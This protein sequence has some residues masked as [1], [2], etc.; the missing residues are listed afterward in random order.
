MIFERDSL[1]AVI[2]NIRTPQAGGKESTGTAVFIA[3]DKKPILLSAAHVLKHINENSYAILSNGQGTP[4]KIGLMR[5][6]GKETFHNHPSADLAKVEIAVTPENQKILQKR[7]FPYGQIDLSAKSLS[8]EL[9]LTSIGFPM[10][11]GV[12]GGKF[13]PL[14]FR[15]YVSSPSISLARFDTKTPCDFIILETPA[16]GGYS[17]GPLFDLGYFISGAM[18]SSSGKTV[19]HGIVHGTISDKTGGKLAAITPS[20]YLKDWL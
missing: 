11:L 12:T 7:C 5:L 1:G 14:T 20:K 8:K 19:L 18:R 2:C 10:G 15:T 13:T 9:Q 6:L 4:Q 17:G 3:K 16:I